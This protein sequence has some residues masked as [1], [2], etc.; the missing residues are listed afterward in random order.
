[1]Q[2]QFQPQL[3]TA[4]EWLAS[5]DFPDKY[6]ILQR[7][8]NDRLRDDVEDIESEIINYSGLVNQGVRPEQAINMLANERQVKRDNPGLGNTG[9]SGSFQNRQVG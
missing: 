6:K 4:E 3:I 1:M 9:N 8:R 5:Q 7:I 2:Y